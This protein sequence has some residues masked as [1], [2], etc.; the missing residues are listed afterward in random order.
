MICGL[1]AT[2]ITPGVLTCPGCQATDGRM[3]AGWG[4]AMLLPAFLLLFVGFMATGDA[5]IGKHN[6]TALTVGI[7]CLAAAACILWMILKKSPH[8]WRQSD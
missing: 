4:I 1:C 7:L 8:G 6:L 3:L 5:L 2:E